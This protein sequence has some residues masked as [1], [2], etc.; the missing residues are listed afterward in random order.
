MIARD[1]YDNILSV[2]LRAIID[3]QG[4]YLEADHKGYMSEYRNILRKA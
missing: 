3:N 4:V 2:I 1:Q